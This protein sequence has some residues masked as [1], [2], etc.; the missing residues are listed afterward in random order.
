MQKDFYRSRFWVARGVRGAGFTLIEIMVVVAIIGIVAALAVP[1]ISAT[2]RA[3]RAS[4]AAR[5]MADLIG[6]ARSEAIR[7]GV[8]QV[9]VFN[10]AALASVS[11][12]PVSAAGN[13]ANPAGAGE[14]MM[15]MR[16]RDANGDGV[17]SGGEVRGE[18]PFNA[19]LVFGAASVG[20]VSAPYDIGNTSSFAANGT[21]FV[22]A[23]GGENWIGFMFLPDGLPRSFSINGAGTP[24]TIGGVGTGGGA[25]YFELADPPRSYAIQVSAGGAVVVSRY[26][27]GAWK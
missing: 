24:A 23:S 26:G 17:P 1:G 22:D 11:D 4:G 7:D 18:V 14:E 21:S 27:G 6:F 9:V 16:F 20:G 12:M 5:D 13:L 19:D 8:N 15:A 3:S 2:M 10:V 25:V